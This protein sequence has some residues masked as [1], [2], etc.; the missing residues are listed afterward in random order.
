[1]DAGS[2]EHNANTLRGHKLAGYR[3]VKLRVEP[4]IEHVY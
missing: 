1:V 4:H 2:S 3:R